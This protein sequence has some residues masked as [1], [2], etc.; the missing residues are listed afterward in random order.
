[1]ADASN[2]PLLDLDTL[3]E[4]PFIAIDGERV[5]IL[6]PAE[7]SVIESH[8]FGVWG[9]RIEQ[10]ANETGKEA[11]D[12]LEELLATV[13]RKIC[14]GASDEQFAKV[15]GSQ[16][17]AIFDLFTGLLLREKLTVAGAMKAAIG[18]VPAWIGVNSSPA[19]SGST[20]DSRRTGWKR[21][22]PLW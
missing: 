18:E 5:N 20:A 2:K 7:L 12:E 16:Q 8:R 1:M 13:S 22:L 6:N 15:S 21:F 9:R 10:L 4:R 14:V 3:V 17:W 11:E 19:S